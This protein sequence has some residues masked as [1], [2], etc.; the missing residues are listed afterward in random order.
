MLSV[1]VRLDEQMPKA[2]LQPLPLLRRPRRI[3][4]YPTLPI[5]LPVML[6]ILKNP[7]DFPDRPSLHAL[8]DIYP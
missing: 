4:A 3:S 6:S 5:L 1:L 7:R 2:D 8:D